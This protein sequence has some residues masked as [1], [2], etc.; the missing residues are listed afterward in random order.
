[1]FLLFFLTLTVKKNVTGRTQETN[2]CI[3]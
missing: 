2:R 1:V 3:W